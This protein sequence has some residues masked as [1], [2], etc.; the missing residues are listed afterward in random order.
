LKHVGGKTSHRMKENI[1]KCNV[2]FL[3]KR[4]YKTYT[5]SFTNDK[6]YTLCLNWCIHVR[7]SVEQF[8]NEV[9]LV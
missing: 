4:E 1:C 9:Q 6:T 5:H 3:T 2:M 8:L 7:L